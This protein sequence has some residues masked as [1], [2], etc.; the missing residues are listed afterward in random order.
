MND[1]NVCKFFPS[2]VV[3]FSGG[4]DMRLKIWSAEN[5][6]CPVTLVGHTAAIND[7][8][9]VERGKCVVSAG[10]D[11]QCKV[12]NV[13]ESRCVAT[14]AKC[15]CVINQ[16]VVQQINNA[17]VWQQLGHQQESTSISGIFV[18]FVLVFVPEWQ[19]FL[20]F[21]QNNKAN[22]TLSASLSH[23]LAMTASCVSSHSRRTNKYM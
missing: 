18:H 7:V 16:C 6:S 21:I 3:V 15:S 17:A 12:F 23:V 11:G 10:R 13:G 5:G 22:Q 1:V 20:I 8:A 2:G 19:L 4:V 9:F 14:L